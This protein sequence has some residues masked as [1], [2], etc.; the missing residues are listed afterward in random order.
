MVHKHKSRMIDNRIERDDHG[1]HGHIQCDP[2]AAIKRVMQHGHDPRDYCGHD[3]D[4]SGGWVQKP[5]S[6][7]K[8]PRHPGSES[9]GHSNYAG[10]LTPRKA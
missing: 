9:K 8:S 2:K 1:R 3:G 5:A 6:Y 4:M 10:Q 7:S